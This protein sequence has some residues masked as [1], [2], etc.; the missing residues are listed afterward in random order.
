M[1]QYTNDWGVPVRGYESAMGGLYKNE[2]VAL[3]VSEGVGPC[4]AVVRFVDVYEAF[5]ALEHILKYDAD[6]LGAIGLSLARSALK[7]SRRAKEKA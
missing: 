3:E 7:N 4:H 5:E 6:V 1:N 2:G